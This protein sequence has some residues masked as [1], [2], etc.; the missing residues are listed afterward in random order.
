MYGRMVPSTGYLKD[1]NLRIYSPGLLISY[2][3]SETNGETPEFK[4]EPTFAASL[5]E[6]KIGVNS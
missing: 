4:D 6:T 5:Y 1:F 2:P 3:R